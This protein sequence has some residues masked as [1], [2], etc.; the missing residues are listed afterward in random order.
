MTQ[1][2]IS[3]GLKEA[4]PSVLATSSHPGA[5]GR[6]RNQVLLFDVGIAQRILEGRKLL[7]MGADAPGQKNTFGKREH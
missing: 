4:T 2:V 3:P 1:K 7:P 6:H 5:Y